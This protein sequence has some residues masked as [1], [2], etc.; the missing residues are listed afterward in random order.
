MRLHDVKVSVE[1]GAITPLGHYGDLGERCPAHERENVRKPS[2][3]AKGLRSNITII[4]G[5][6]FYGSKSSK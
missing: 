5:E 2:L 1:G 3:P 6:N 4:V